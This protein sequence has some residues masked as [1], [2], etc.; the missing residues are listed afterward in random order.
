MEGGIVPS[1]PL[2]FPMLEG[3]ILDRW[4]SLISRFICEVSG[5]VSDGN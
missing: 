2:N 3:T 4:L 1:K 5:Q